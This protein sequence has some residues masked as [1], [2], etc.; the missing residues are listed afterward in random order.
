M[1]LGP[2]NQSCPVGWLG[3]RPLGRKEEKEEGPRLPE[4]AVH[5]SGGRSYAQRPRRQQQTPTAAEG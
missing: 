2:T 4:A 5:R 1:A 3:R